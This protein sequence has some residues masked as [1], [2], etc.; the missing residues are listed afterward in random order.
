[1]LNNNAPDINDPA[2]LAALLAQLTGSPTTARP[3]G[4]SNLG[5]FAHNYMSDGGN[6]SSAAASTID[7]SKLGQL[8]NATGMS[9]PTPTAGSSTDST[10]KKA[11]LGAAILGL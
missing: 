10:A 3:A 6:F 9:G 2:T 7:S 1:M 4:Q 8:V 11:G 5:N